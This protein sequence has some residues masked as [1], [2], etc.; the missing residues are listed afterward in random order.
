MRGAPM[1]DVDPITTEDEQWVVTDEHGYEW[2]YVA[3][4]TV[5]EALDEAVRHAL[6]NGD[7]SRERTTW[8]ESGAVRRGDESETW[9]AQHDPEEPECLSPG[10]HDWRQ[11]SVVGY[12]GGVVVAEECRC[13]GWARYTN[14]WASWGAVQGLRS[15]SYT[16]RERDS[17]DFPNDEE[18][19]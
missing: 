6:L 3:G 8:W 19:Y 15:V 16:K 7:V 14:T 13:C 1:S 10:G 9:V 12:G 4:N 17:E 11:V 18:G 2:A 5:E